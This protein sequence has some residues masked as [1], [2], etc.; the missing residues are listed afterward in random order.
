MEP[1]CPSCR[2][3]LK[4]SSFSM[5]ID[6]IIVRSIFSLTNI[7]IESKLKQPMKTSLTNNDDKT[8][9]KENKENG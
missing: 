6:L 2:Q 5:V 3:I 7:Q 8:I 4:I 9:S 1:L